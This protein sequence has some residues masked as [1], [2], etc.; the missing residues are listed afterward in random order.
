MDK[1]T[2]VSIAHKEIIPGSP[3]NFEED[4]VDTVYQMLSKNIELIGG[5]EQIIKTGDCNLLKR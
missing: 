3:G 1:K 5:I 4:A 2:K